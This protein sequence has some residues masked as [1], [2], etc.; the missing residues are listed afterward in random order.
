M[1]EKFLYHL[2]SSS[3]MPTLPNDS[4]LHAIKRENQ[5]L[6]ENVEAFRNGDYESYLS[7][8][9]DLLTEELKRQRGQYK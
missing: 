8:K 4:L 5:Q 2:D 9:I 1:L 6:Q 3:N 7:H